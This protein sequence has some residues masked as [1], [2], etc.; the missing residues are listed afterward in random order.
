SQTISGCESKRIAVTA[1]I[2][3]TPA[4]SGNAIQPF[5]SGQN[6]TIANIVVN[7]VA[8]KWYD[9]I[10]N[11][12][13]LTSSTSLHNGV[14]YYASQTLNSCEGQRF[15]VTVSIQNTPSVPTGDINPKFCKS[16]NATLNDI[17]INGQNIK[18]YDSN[19]STS[20]LLST[21]LLL[22]NKT[23]YVSQS[24][25]CES[26]RL[27]V[28]VNVYDT[29]LPRANT[30]QIFCID[31]NALIS[32]I[33]ISGNDI[34]WYDAPT[35]GNILTATTQLASGTYYAT[36]TLNNCEST[37]IPVMIKIQDTP[38]P[39]ADLNQSFCI[40]QNASISKINISGQN[41]NW[42][43]AITAGINLSESTPLEN[44]ITYYASQTINDCESERTPIT[45]QIVEATM[46]DCINYVEELPFP[47]FFTPNNDGHN[48]TW[49]IDFTYLA[50]NSSI[51]IFDRYGKFIKELLKDTDWDGTYIGHDEPAS[52]YW[53]V[54]TRLNGAQ[55]RGHFSLKR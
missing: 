28:T 7:G 43:D 52:D 42:Y 22:N 48:D 54:V 15:A 19:T 14:T 47:K 50:P 23:Y 39:I 29:A 27:A 36:Q 18:W 41:I 26:D 24:I 4:P 34:K 55:F 31:E 20:V 21:T 49:T 40:Q 16:E 35:A 33:I 44:G 1:T 10:T 11:G 9:A 12:N 51:R 2:H 13:L 45:I 5:C 3:N 38:A 25:G 17:V 53:F 37:R 30:P 46:G 8:I 6:P 32:N